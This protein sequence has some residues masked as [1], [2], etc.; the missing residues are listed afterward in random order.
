M[1]KA[2]WTN[3]D[4]LDFCNEFAT[5]CI[6]RQAL[7]YYALN[8]KD[9]SVTP[10]DIMRFPSAEPPSQ[11]IIRCNNCKFYEGVHGVL[12][13]APCTYWGLGGVMYNDYCSRGEKVHNE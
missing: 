8:Q 6:S 12:G 2:E 5:D 3:K 11:Q 9:K 10:N 4:A 1:I 7:C 13:H